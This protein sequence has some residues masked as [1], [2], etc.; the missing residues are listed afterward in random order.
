MSITLVLNMA[1]RAVKVLTNY[2]TM[3]PCYPSRELAAKE[4]DNPLRKGWFEDL[5]F[6]IGTGFD[7]NNAAAVRWLAD[8]RKE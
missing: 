5:Y 2:F 1:S 3:V 4:G 7:H 6:G 8:R